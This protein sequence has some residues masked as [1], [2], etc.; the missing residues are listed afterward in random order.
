MSPDD[1]RHGTYAGVQA[2]WKAGQ[3]ITSCQACTDANYRYSKRMRVRVQRG[4]RN[5]VPLGD[6]A[7]AILTTFSGTQLAAATGLSRNMLYRLRTNPSG[8][9]KIV[10]RTTRDRILRARPRYTPLGI[11]R[12]LRAL[13]RL[14]YS[15]RY[16]ADALGHK[17]VDPLLSIMRKDRPTFVRHDYGVGIADLY[18]RLHMTPAA[19]SRASSRARNTAIAR[20]YHGPLAWD[21]IDTDPEPAKVV[22]RKRDTLAEYEHLTSLGVS[23]DQALKQLGITL[24]GLEAAMR[25]ERR[26][27]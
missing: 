12:R 17:H 15:A 1:P 16:I 24:D 18:D 10:T 5:R 21:D 26:A 19:P 25:R 23:R 22:D 11:Q 27:S 20:G 4:V 8:P 2:H 9:D 3:S 13:M 14:G 7:W 6:E